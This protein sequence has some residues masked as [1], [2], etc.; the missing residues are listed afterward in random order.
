MLFCILSFIFVVG[1]VTGLIFNENDGTLTVLSF[2][3]FVTLDI[4]DCLLFNSLM[5]V[6][7]CG[8]LAILVLTCEDDK[9]PN[10]L[11]VLFDEGIIMSLVF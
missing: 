6:F 2:P 9:S 7:A 11:R 10:A 4:V 1:A 8:V 3:P 5:L